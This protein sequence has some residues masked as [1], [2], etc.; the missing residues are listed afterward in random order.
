MRLLIAM[1]IILMILG[2]VAFVI[3]GVRQFA[4]RHR[5]AHA[6]WELE[7]QAE[8]GWLH[9]WAVKPGCEAEQLAD[10]IKIRDEFFDA[11]LFEKRLEARERLSALNDKEKAL[12]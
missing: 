3:A 6:P 12:R 10:P 2:M 11:N 7:E 4:L 1:L 9:F 5:K 8:D